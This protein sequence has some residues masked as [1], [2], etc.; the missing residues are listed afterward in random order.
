M[1]KRVKL[2]YF[3]NIIITTG[4]L[5]TIFTG[6]AVNRHIQLADSSFQKKQYDNALEH[7][8]K[9]LKKNPESIDLRIKIDK[10]LKEASAH[11]YRLGVQQEESGNKKRAVLLFGRALE[12]DPG[13]SDARYALSLLTQKEKII[14]TK[15]TIRKELEINT[16]LPPI[17]K[18][19]DKLDLMFKS[20]TSLKAIFDVLSKTGK[21]NILFDS[22]FLDKPVMVTLLDITFYQAMERMCQLFNL[23]YYVLDDRH[24]IIAPD[25]G[26]SEKRYKKILMKNFYL[27]NVDAMEAKK[28]VNSVLKPDKL[29]VNKLTN[30]L[31]VTDSI[32][33]VSLVGKLLQFVDKRKGEVEIEVEI[34]EIDK[35]KLR[36]FGTELS[37]WQTSISIDG[38][39]SGLPITDLDTITKGSFRVSIPQAV[40]KYFSSI[41]D[42][43]IL[44][45]PKVRGIDQ[46]DINIQLGEKRPIPR[47][48]FVPVSTGGVNQQPITSYTLTDVGIMLTITPA[49]H[50]NREVTL[51]LKFELT[52]VIDIGSTFVPP[53][54]GSRRVST[55]LR[56]RDGETGI[57]A[58]LMKDTTTG[59]RNGIPILNQIPIL[60]SIFSSNSKL[61]DR[62]DILLSI[63][64]RIIR[65]PEIS[66]SDTDAYLIG[67]RKKKELKRWQGYKE[68][69]P[70]KKKTKKK[71][72]PPRKRKGK[73]K[74][75]SPPK[76][77]PSET[78]NKT[79]SN[80]K[81]GAGKTSQDK[82]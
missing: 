33:V 10:I 80:P 37:S 29:I 46:Q 68:E 43:R 70:A 48:T 53:T 8:F 15:E 41:T 5:I 39:E 22:A 82:T 34:L 13:N 71:K 12:F 57:I 28:V 17:L 7:Y 72:R 79:K 69:D 61:K 51:D 59:S 36:E 58:G 24:I 26:E 78:K 63:T 25:T 75:T 4:L 2:R 35:R 38:T 32:E 67:T 55:T 52:N 47:T 6:C 42:S 66:K 3:F 50:N 56:L 30:S 9:A 1:K 74:K 11:Y 49:I 18:N 54:L 21:V 60:K 23:Q 45:R 40:W 44:A 27:V 16:G 62:Q 20:P 73:K 76:K 19:P 14:K 77:A 64:P 65:M 81:K 31:I